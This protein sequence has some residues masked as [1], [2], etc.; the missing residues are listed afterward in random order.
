MTGKMATAL[1]SC[2]VLAGC[3]GQA[4][5][6]HLAPELPNVE[7]YRNHSCSISMLLTRL[8]SLWLP[9]SSGV[10]NTPM[11][12]RRHLLELFDATVDVGDTPRI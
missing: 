7:T 6:T 5:I 3:A 12:L 1:L 8:P 11:E 4:A 9:I 2:L 10:E